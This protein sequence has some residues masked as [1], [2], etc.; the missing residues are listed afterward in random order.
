MH[1]T[2]TDIRTKIYKLFKGEI[3]LTILILKD[4]K[5]LHQLQ[6]SG[7]IL[8]SRNITLVCSLNFIS[9]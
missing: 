1:S 5:N 6:S 9:F 7:I 2:Y 3:K 4:G 8:N